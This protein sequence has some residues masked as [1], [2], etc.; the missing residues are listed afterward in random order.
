MKKGE[1]ETLQLLFP[2][3]YQTHDLKVQVYCERNFF[4]G[5]TKV[6]L[7]VNN[8]VVVTPVCLPIRLESSVPP[9]SLLKVEP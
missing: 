6:F 5:T 9:F 1:A 7:R 4:G 2:S 8:Q 3:G